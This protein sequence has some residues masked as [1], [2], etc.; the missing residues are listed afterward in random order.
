MPGTPLAEAFVRVRADTSRFKDDIRDAFKGVGDDFG[1]QFSKE[2]TD[3][4][5][6]ERGRFASAGS[7]L[8]DAAGDSAGAQL[9]R[10]MAELGAVQFGDDGNQF[11]PVGTQIGDE[12]GKAAGEAFGARF[13]KDA[14]GRWHDER[15]RFVSEATAAGEESGDGFSKGFDR[16]MG[17]GNGRGRRHGRDFGDGFSDG[18]GDALRR[19]GDIGGR[20]FNLMLPDLGRLASGFGSAASAAGGLL[21]SVGKWTAI[22]GGVASLGAAAAS[23][24]GYTVELAAALAPVGGLTAALP[25]VLLTGV[26]ALTAWKLATYGVGEAMGAVW[27]GDAKALE[28]ALEKLTPAAHAFVTEFEAAKP[29]FKSF[30]EAAQ[31]GF[32]SQLSGS[33]SGV[34]QALG[35]IKQPLRDLASEF[36]GLVRE[37][38]NFA[39]AQQ[40][41]SQFSRILGNTGQ[42]VGA[43]WS[44]MQPLL[45]GFVDLGTVGSDWLA[46]M[47]GGLTSSLTKFGE[48]M[49]R[50]AESGQ[51]FAWMDGAAAVLKQLGALAKDVWD[52]LAG[53][54]NA[55]AAAGGNALGVLGNLVDGFAKWVNSTKGQDVLVEIFRALGDIGRALLPVITA[56][57]GALAGL[58][59]TIGDLA[60]L[61]GPILTTA[62]NAL[63]PAI[64][65]LGPGVI[66]V[67]TN[68]GIAV[69][70]LADSGALTL[71]GQAIADILIALA[72]LLPAL[73]DILVPVL[74]GLALLVTSVVAPALSTLV[75]WIK[76]A[77]DWIMN[78]AINDDHPLSRF[79]TFVRD[80]LGPVVQK[81]WGELSTAFSSIATW[82]QANRSTFEEWQTKIQDIF[83]IA[84]SVWTT[85]SDLIA[86]VFT[87]I[88]SW[89]Q[90]NGDKFGEWGTRLTSIFH[91]VAEIVS[92]VW[93]AI[94][95]AW[96]TFGGPLLD[97]VGG[98]FSAILQ[99]I[100]GVMQAIKGLIDVVMGVI[101]GDWDR[102]WNG[103]KDVFGGIW[104]AI[105]GILNAA[106][107]IIKYQI[108]NALAIVGETWDGAWNKVKGL[109]ES[110][111]NSI[112]KTVSDKI[113][114]VRNFIGRLS[115]IPGQVSNW[116][117]QVKDSISAKLNDAVSFVQSI[118]GRIVSAF[119]NM[120]SL[121]RDSGRS[122]IQGLIDGLY[123]KLQD[124]YNSAADILNRIRSLF[125]FSPAKEGPFSGKGWTLYSG[126][127][128]MAGLAAGILRQEGAVTGAMDQVM[129]SASASLVP[130]VAPAI[131]PALTGLAAP[132]DA[133]TSPSAFSGTF[134][135]PRPAGESTSAGVSIQGDLVVQVQGI[136]DPNNPSSFRRF[137][138]QLR[139][140]IR[141]LEREVYQG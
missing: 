101:T 114:D 3:R 60:K 55:A 107:S 74:E 90:N 14:Q 35:A 41:V 54:L 4:L 87:D 36:G 33:L 91:N 88:S 131:T 129:A 124:A 112:T 111:W 78:A 75:G 85:I 110:V 6:D 28:A 77:V 132:S 52:I 10:R 23:S 100:D 98:V 69:Q 123:S 128:L 102:A 73:A 117:G 122:L 76:Q 70:T 80:T 37:T 106:W 134:G 135:A 59:P 81:V 20:V 46:S 51:A 47:S 15:G 45:K 127:S 18:L 97:L 39:T 116:F 130:L 138:E 93:E 24:A 17:D 32:F 104:E 56:L 108:S 1:K 79:A 83:A 38:L 26:A 31:S 99:V 72:P 141:G 71:I 57:A 125:P 65:A 139:A 66:A 44:A 2:A 16:R 53:L 50:V 9:G 42:L 109:L 95:L 119:G 105:K 49:S 62:I 43:L 137:A 8:G 92:G 61:I 29:A 63:A 67:F 58:A 68:L 22:A 27:S 94:S 115:E 120:G 103:V 48:W 118:P 19:L 12:T 34:A 96:D 25:G 89:V 30:Q 5:R 40:T 11:V 84:Q 7:D 113:G 136:L 64:E 140:E 86:K 21:A 121:L 82:V 13:T 133:L 126:Q